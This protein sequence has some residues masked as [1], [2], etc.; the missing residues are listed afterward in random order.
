MNDLRRFVKQV[1]SRYM[2]P[3]DDDYIYEDLEARITQELQKT[4]EPITKPSISQAFGKIGGNDFIQKEFSVYHNL[5]LYQKSTKIILIIS[6]GSVVISAIVFVFYIFMAL[7]TMMRVPYYNIAGS[8]FGLFDINYETLFVYYWI[9]K[10]LLMFVVSIVLLVSDSIWKMVPNSII[11]LFFGIIT[12]PFGLFLMV[13]SI[14]KVITNRIQLQKP[15]YIKLSSAALVSIVIFC[16]SIVGL[17]QTK[18]HDEAIYHEDMSTLYTIPLEELPLDS[19]IV[20][21]SGS[22]LQFHEYDGIV[23]EFGINNIHLTSSIT[24]SIGT[25]SAFFVILLNDVPMCTMFL[26]GEQLDDPVLCYEQNYEI[27]LH[28]EYLDVSSIELSMQFFYNNDYL[29]GFVENYTVITIE[30]TNEYIEEYY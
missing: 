24:D 26:S 13:Y 15:D 22:V 6:A 11:G 9:V 20:D 5:Q 8:Y 23:Y 12:L 10:T 2:I 21:L 19:P 18:A 28:D 30:S 1:L 14:Y 17:N 25:H 3:S 7:I 27:G 4:G 29:D 16:I